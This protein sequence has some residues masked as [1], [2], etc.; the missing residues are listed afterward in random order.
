MKTKFHTY[1]EG[2][3]R[4]DVA[5]EA[6]SEA[7]NALAENYEMKTIKVTDEDGIGIA[8]FLIEKSTGKAVAMTEYDED[9]I[10]PSIYRNPEA[11]YQE[12]LKY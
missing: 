1:L 7:I 10:V 11:E 6:T 2:K 3:A 12:W 9:G 5:Y 8:N 4:T